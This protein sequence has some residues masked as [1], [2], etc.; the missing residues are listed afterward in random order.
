MCIKIYQFLYIKKKFNSSMNKKTIQ[1][2]I[3]LKSENENL[4]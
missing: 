1:Y 2:K 3:K 4:L